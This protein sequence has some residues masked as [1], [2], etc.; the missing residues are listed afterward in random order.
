MVGWT[1]GTRVLTFGSEGEPSTVATEESIA[2]ES[3]TDTPEISTAV[4]LG[5]LAVI[6]P[7][8]TTGNLLRVD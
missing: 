6:V 1:W 3:G 4:G 2:R 7:E 8:D 5:S